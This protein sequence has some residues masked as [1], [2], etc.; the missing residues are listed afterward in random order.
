MDADAEKTNVEHP[1]TSPRG[2]S[3][4]SLALRIATALALVAAA[5]FAVFFAAVIDWLAC[6]TEP[7]QACDRKDLARLQLQIAVVGLAPIFAFAVAW[8]GEWRRVAV[9]MFILAV[10][11]Y[12][13][14][15]VLAD[16]AV[17]GWDDLKFFPS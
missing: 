8:I 12:L 6:D 2:S 9:A 15:A 3:L 13:T 4:R 1:A 10:G 11:S 5:V 17:H 16:A 14:W 7:S